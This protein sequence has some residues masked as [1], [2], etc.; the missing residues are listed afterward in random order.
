[1]YNMDWFH[2]NVCRVR[3]ETT[4]Y[5]TSCGHILCKTCITQEY[6]SVCRTA[7]K[8]LP[9]SENL[10]PQEKIYFR[11][12]KETVQKDFNS[13]SQAWSFQKQQH[14]LHVTFYKQYLTKAQKA[15]QEALQK[16]ENQ[17]NDLKAMTRENAELR[18][19]VTHLKS[20]LSRSQSSSRSCTPRP[21]AITPP[22]QTVTP[23]YSFQ[24]C[25]QIASRSPSVESLPYV[26]SH[27]G[28][29]SQSAS[30]SRVHEGTT[31]ISSSQGSP[32]SGH[33]MSYRLPSQPTSML[34]LSYP[35]DR[36]DISSNQFQSPNE[37]SNI[38]RT[39]SVARDSFNAPSNNIDRLRAIQLKFTPKMP[40]SLGLRK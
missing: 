40:G 37:T 34:N 27:S 9:I 28:T 11:S 32:M 7:C 23:R 13:I 10:K 33:S 5:I 15:F 3:Q 35:G 16:I 17:E 12:L 8:Y 20:S 18:S 39:N 14:E 4:F 2:C 24:Q 19:M 26:R 31:P 36:S 1:M 30:T 6:C 22:S 38:F 21:I 29:G 25:G